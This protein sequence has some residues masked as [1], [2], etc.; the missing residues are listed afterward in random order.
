MAKFDPK[1]QELFDWVIS[2]MAVS[3]KFNFQVL[4]M[5]RK[6][7][8]NA[9]PTMAVR[10]VGINIELMVNPNFFRTL[11][12]PELRYVLAHEVMHVVLHHI[13]KR[14]PQDPREMKLF[15]YAADM[16][17]N[18]LLPDTDKRKL[19]TLKDIEALRNGSDEEMAMAEAMVACGMEKLPKGKKPGDLNGIRPDM[20]EFGFANK[21]SQEN[22]VHLL[23]DKFPP[24][25]DDCPVHGD[26]GE[27]K[28]DEGDGDQDGE[29][30]GSGEEEGEGQGGHGHGGDQECT[31]GGGGLPQMGGF[32][33]HDYWDEN[34]VV[35][36]QIRQK[37]EHIDKCNMW[38]DMQGDVQDMI[39]AAQETEVPWHKLLRQYLGTLI[40]SKW[41]PTRKRPNRRFGYAFS[42]TKRDTV[43]RK[44]VAIDTSGSV[45]DD[46][47]QVF[48]AEINKLAEIQPVDLMLFDH[49]L[50]WERAKPFDR[51]QSTLD[52]IGRGGTE[53]QQV[54]D[55]AEEHRYKT[56]IVLTDGYAPE[57]IQ[58]TRH[59]TCWVITPDGKCPVDWGEQIKMTGDTYNS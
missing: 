15:N 6:T 32:D 24:K 1:T 43:D 40:S 18:S 23:R 3:D 55:Y 27:P 14:K 31:C 19:P 29:G 42:G 37:V 8:T 56:L 45:G 44:L 46:D 17:I 50:A 57:P 34:E 26:C 16:A 41:A 4:A 48:L 28:K 20:P 36:S 49:G 51:R 22:Y 12:V 38:G 33:E 30:K 9:I 58:P 52:I 35:D 59:D 39:R 47:L 7:V 21:L 54:F 13:T 53:F 5:M 2:F 25:P 10:P 11:T